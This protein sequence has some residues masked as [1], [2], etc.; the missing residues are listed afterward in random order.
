LTALRTSGLIAVAHLANRGPSLFSGICLVEYALDLPGLG[1]M[2]VQA[3]HDSNVSWLMLSACFS[4]ALAGLLQIAGD[5]WLKQF[6]TGEE[7]L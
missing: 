7:H 4:T 2:T 6:A 5:L 1:Q 3:I